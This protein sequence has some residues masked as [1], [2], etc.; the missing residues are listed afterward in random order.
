MLEPNVVTGRVLGGTYY[1]VVFPLEIAGVHDPL[2]I[3]KVNDEDNLS[4]E[5]DT[6]A[7]SE[8]P[9]ALLNYRDE[10]GSVE[11]QLSL[12]VSP[13][14]VPQRFDT[15]SFVKL[16]NQILKS[17]HPAG[18]LRQVF[19]VNDQRKGWRAEEQKS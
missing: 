9:Q 4:V 6:R 12:V 18:S 17:Q 10:N 16:S 15:G 19:L 3:E 7:Y 11:H 14:T 2:G 1:D 13:V 5:N 8:V